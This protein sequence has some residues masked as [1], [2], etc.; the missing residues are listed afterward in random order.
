MVMAL[1]ILVSENFIGS[2]SFVYLFGD[3]ILIEDKPGTCLTDLIAEF[4]QYQ[5]SAV[6]AAQLM[7][8]ERIVTGGSI[9]YLEKPTVPHQ[10]EYLIEK[11]ATARKGPL[12]LYDR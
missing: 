3:D 6:A 2:D 9:K 4:N 10:M 12:S 11:P 1:P 8:P 7:S 5:P